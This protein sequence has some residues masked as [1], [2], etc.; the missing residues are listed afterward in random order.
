M[1]NK[2]FRWKVLTGK[3]HLKEPRIQLY[4]SIVLLNNDSN[5]ESEEEAMEALENLY[6]DS[7]Y[8]YTGLTLVTFYNIQ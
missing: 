8:S 7:A 5:F 1:I 4:K 3:G 6:R 2:S